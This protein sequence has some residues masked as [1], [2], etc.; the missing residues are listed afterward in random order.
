MREILGFVNCNCAL[1]GLQ[2]EY[3]FTWNDFSDSPVRLQLCLSDV[4]SMAYNMRVQEILDSVGLYLDS[5]S[6]ATKVER[7]G[8]RQKKKSLSQS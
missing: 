1:L 8:R 3:M 4:L 2:I 7:E 5:K 6:I